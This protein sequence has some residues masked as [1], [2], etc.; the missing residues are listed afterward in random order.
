VKGV[1]IYIEGGGDSTNGKAQLR[2]GFEALLARQKGQ[3]RSKR[4]GWKLVLCGGRNATADAF[5]VEDQ[6]RTDEIVVLLVDSED[7]IA[8]QSPNGRVGHLRRRDGWPLQD[9]QADRVHLM[10]R[11]M[12][13]WVVSDPEALKGYYGQHFQDSALPKRAVLDDEPKQA[14]DEAL[15]SATKRTQ[16]G[17]YGKI[18][19]A[20]D[21]LQKIDATKVAKRCTSFR[22]F[23]NWLERAIAGS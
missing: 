14:L 6:A 20:G 15:H 12:E 23:V 18:K 4:M 17:E 10:T 13:A 1:R 9:Y 21:L 7:P 22:Q 11:C 19:H 5:L 8:D 3:A 16:K 2:L